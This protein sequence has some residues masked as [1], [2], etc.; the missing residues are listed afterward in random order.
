MVAN[1]VG[2]VNFEWYM[3]SQNKVGDFWLSC[4]VESL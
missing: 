1:F 4:F 2:F 3:Y